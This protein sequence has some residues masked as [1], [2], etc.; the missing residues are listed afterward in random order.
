MAVKI[1]SVPFFNDCFQAFDRF[2]HGSIVGLLTFLFMLACPSDLQA[3]D[4]DRSLHQYNTRTWRRD[5]GLP[6]NAVPAMTVTN[7]GRLWLG[8]S[9]GIFHFDGVEFHGLEDDTA[10]MLQGRIITALQARPEGGF[11][12]GT[13][14][15]L[16]MYD[17]EKIISYPNPRWME[18]S[19]MNVRSIVFT[20]DQTLVLGT[21][22]GGIRWV[23]E[24]GQWEL[25]APF[26]NTDVFSLFEDPHGNLWVGT[27]ERGVYVLKEGEVI[28]FWGSGMITEITHDIVADA[29]GNVWMATAEDL[30]WFNPDGELV[31]TPDMPGQP[32]VLHIDRN[33]SVWLGTYGGGVERGLVRFFKDRIEQFG[34]VDGLAADQI[35]SIA[36]T[37]DGSIWIGTGDGLTQFLNVKFPTFAIPDGLAT[38]RV[39]AVAA[40]PFGGVWV[41]T[42]DGVAYY[43]GETFHNYGNMGRDGFSSRWVKRI[44]PAANG[45]V[46]FIGARKNI[47]RFRGGQVVESWLFDPWPRAIAET[48]RGIIAGIADDIKILQEGSFVP[49]LLADGTPARV[50][51][52]ND[53]LVDDQGTIW[54]ASESGIFAIRDGEMLDYAQRN[55]IPHERYV[56]LTL[57]RDGV[58]WAVGHRGIMRIRDGQM[59]LVGREH[60]LHDIGI[61]A[62]LADDV[63]N[64]WVDS[65]RGI[66]RVS[67]EDMHAVADGRQSQLRS[68]VFEGPNVVKTTDKVALEYSGARSVDGRIWFPSSKG[69]IMIDPTQV[70][71]ESQPPTATITRLRINGRLFGVNELQDIEPGPGNLEINY[72]ALDYQAPL[73]V[74][75]RY[76][77][78]GFD[79]DWVDAGNRR[80]AFYTNL[81]PGNYRFEVQAQNVDGVWDSVGARVDIF[82][83]PTYYQTWWFR[84]VVA[85]LVAALIIYLL[86]VRNLHQRQAHL[87]QAHALMEANVRTRTAELASANE[88]LRDEIEQRK[89]AQAETERLHDEL[90][91]SAEAAHQ[92]A[93]AKSLFLANMSH[94]IRTP[95]NGIIGM[96]NLLLGTELNGQQREFAETTRNSAESLL[97]ILNDILDFSKMEAGKLSFEEVVFDLRNTV[98]ESLELLALRAGSKG[99]EVA[100][101]VDP[102]VESHWIG[103]PGRLRQV[104]VNLI[105]NAVKFTEE[106]EVLVEVK[107][108]EDGSLRF[109]VKDTG[110]GISKEEQAKLFQ[111]FSQA[112]NSTTRR[113]GGTGLGLAISR[114]IV[115]QMGG[116]V[117][118]E[119]A[120]GEGS[121]FW[122]TARFKPTPHPEGEIR[123][124]SRQLRGQSMLA[125]CDNPTTRKVLQHYADNWQISL[126]LVDSTNEALQS[127]TQGNDGDSPSWRWVIVALN[128]AENGSM[129]CLSKVAQQLYS[130]HAESHTALILLTSLQHRL[131]LGSASRHQLRAILTLPVRGSAL[132]EALLDSVDIQ[133]SK[134]LP[135]G[136]SCQTVNADTD[137]AD[138]GQV[139][140]ILVAEDNRVNQRVLELQLKKAGHDVSLVANGQEVMAAL[141]RDSFDLVFMDC[142]MPVMDGYEATRAIRRDGRFD[143]LQI[144]AMT[145]NTLEGDREKC[146]AAGMNDYLSKPTRERELLRTLDSVKRILAEKESP[147]GKD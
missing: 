18:G 108:T 78:V 45:D 72:I 136:K 145:A 53:I 23:K 5:T 86:W 3:L 19:P 91:I 70:S 142:Q 47:D 139:L 17:G 69:L 117:G 89:R 98:E 99:V 114:Q 77:L 109:A 126:H 90:R 27:A 21:T 33:D 11:W 93:N 15:G 121:T 10:S 119:S 105:G 2:R 115:E 39:L 68:E 134:K 35:L 97:T 4:P 12:I 133:S 66:Y 81:S 41:G 80:T 111:P 16:A 75:Y 87:R 82:L 110:I 140:R 32:N 7:D 8:T 67:V 118:V 104:L 56:F 30:L 57:D 113:F 116:E 59:D 79:A 1:H 103:D 58:L 38:E 31:D 141:E 146:L 63:G 73:E 83:P 60:G 128:D 51:W 144:I 14:R 125:I 143:G 101:L 61:Y 84:G 112:D 102:E 123:P 132:Y 100:C 122:F 40:S 34:G 135:D 127:I 107:P 9:Q 24:T 76:R 137:T 147:S 124:G 74:R 62:V 48:S 106:G 96:S 71:R 131:D 37:P 94:E 26:L 42:A 36:E 92:A 6:A 50:P 85:L 46:F 65:S 55:G 130:S 64:L 49:Y 138:T 29:K 52:V 22:S 95:M 54:I 44:F 28:P 13:D 120:L 43:D 20:S 25:L 129:E 88:T